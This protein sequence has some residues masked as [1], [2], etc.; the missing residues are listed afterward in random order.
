MAVAYDKVDTLD[1][2]EA[3]ESASLLLDER[4]SLKD[5][6]RQIGLPLAIGEKGLDAKDF[7]SKVN[8]IYYV[9][10]VRK[11]HQALSTTNQWMHVGMFMLS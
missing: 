7:Y 6:T 5:H 9:N 8:P 11:S 3:L 2:L 10:F 4:L 1:K